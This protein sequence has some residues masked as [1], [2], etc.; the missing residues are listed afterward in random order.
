MSVLSTLIRHDATLQYRYGIYAAY[1]FVVAFYVVV[2]TLGRGLLPAWGVGLVIYTDPAAV[3]FF[4]LG[5][6]VML[7]KGEGVRTAL[8]V[9]SLRAAT[10]LA[11]KVATLGSISLGASA[12]LIL[13]HGEV[14][15]PALLLVAVALSSLAFI[16][17]GIPIALRFRTVNGYLVGSASFLSPIIALAGLALLEPMP[18]WMA[19]WPPVAQFRLVL[20]ATGYGTASAAEI[21]AMLVVSIATAAGML[22]WATAALRTE[23]GK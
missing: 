5:A 7:E 9:T 6:L 10:Y 1:A 4:F 12:I 11:A 8:A 19:L 17:L 20:V 16:G 21:A 22:V 13:V 23:L 14:A 15:N 3:G 18:V 2:L